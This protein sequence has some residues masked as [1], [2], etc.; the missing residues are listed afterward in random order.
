MYRQDPHARQERKDIN[1]YEARLPS[2]N[3]FDYYL[4]AGRRLV[5]LQHDG[6]IPPTRNEIASIERNREAWRL[7]EE[8]IRR[9]YTIPDFFWEE[10]SIRYAG[11]WRQL[12]RL[13]NMRIRWHLALHDGMDAVRDWQVGFQFVRHILGDSVINL[14]VGKTCESL[15][16]APVITQMDLFSAQECRLMAQSLYETETRPDRVSSVIEGELRVAFQCFEQYLS[17]AP[18]SLDEVLEGL[19]EVDPQKG[20]PI[21][22][23]EEGEEPT[24]EQKERAR[25]LYEQAQAVKQSP[26][27]YQQLR[28]QVRQQIKRDMRQFAD[29]FA[30]TKGRYIPP[31]STDSPRDLAGAIAEM[32]TPQPIIGQL[33]WEL[34]TRRRLMWLHLKLREYFL[35]EGRYPN[36]LEE[37]NPKEMGIDP[38]SGELFCYRLEGAR[39]RLYSVGRA[40]KDL[41]GVRRGPNDPFDMPEN[42]FLTHNDWR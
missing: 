36:R 14:L 20:I 35:R 4:N 41:G 23:G 28:Q 42:L 6:R 40:G 10:D 30:L 26:T 18:A 39:Y 32:L 27:A 17:D 5:N 15:I 38:F 21:V 29:A 25:M 1:A 3:A 31:P 2:P 24:P 34:R 9:A 37:I 11:Y 22:Y 16:H 33:Y 19:L 12:A 7:V 13:V 8:G